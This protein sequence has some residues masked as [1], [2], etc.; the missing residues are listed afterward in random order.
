[1]SF[2]TI[3]LHIN[4][5]RR[6]KEP[7]AVA[8]SLARRHGAHLIGAYVVPPGVVMADASAIREAFETATHGETFTAEWRTLD[9][10]Q[11]TISKKL[12]PHCRAADLIITN[13]RDPDWQP[14]RLFDEPERLVLDSGRPVLIMPYAG[15]FPAL[16]SRVMIAWNN[17]REATR[18]AFDA[19]PLLKAA[20]EVRILWI[21]P[22]K[23]RTDYGGDPAD[24][25]PAAAIAHTL[26]RHGVKAVA[27]ESIA[28]DMKVADELLSRLADQGTD[29]LVMGCY[30][31]SR[32]SE[33]VFGGVSRD[34]LKHMTVP[35]LMSH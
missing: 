11:P 28:P 30:G 35:V 14:S 17:R 34:I 12:L 26:A 4:D 2:K 23:D 13:Q 22:Q 18:A 21:N 19:L 6:I 15:H 1:M 5:K 10:D 27:S 24:T 33:L 29:L 25:L 20:E 9:S 31:H 16:G 8:V 7:L 32:L 3:L